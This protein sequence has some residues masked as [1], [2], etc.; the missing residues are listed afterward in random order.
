[1]T[2]RPFDQP[3]AQRASAM[4]IPEHRYDARLPRCCRCRCLLSLPA[5]C[6]LRRRPRRD[7]F[8]FV[9]Q[10]FCARR[11]RNGRVRGRSGCSLGRR[12]EGQRRQSR[13]ERERYRHHVVCGCYS[14]RLRQGRLAC[15]DAASDA[16]EHGSVRLRGFCRGAGRGGVR[17]NGHRQNRP[18]AL[19]VRAR[20][21]GPGRLHGAQR[22]IRALRALQRRARRGLR[23]SAG[24]L[25]RTCRRD[26]PTG[27]LR[28]SRHGRRRSR[29]CQCSCDCRNGR[30][31]LCGQNGNRGSRH[32][33]SSRYGRNCQ[34]R[35]GRCDARDFGD[36]DG[37]AGRGGLWHLCGRRRVEDTFAHPLCL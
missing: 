8:S 31:C 22:G 18:H 11:K 24:C 19:L 29:G 37:G 28:H 25:R 12:A 32:S 6:R 21:G 1:M 9:A 3:T 13:S 4:L 30:Y 23:V 10:P 36:C 33:R 7:G 5:R 15:S 35:G 20:R 27:R 17:K 16:S 2:P 34:W 26:R 14:G